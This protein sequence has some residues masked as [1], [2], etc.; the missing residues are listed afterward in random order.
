[1]L[2]LFKMVLITGWNENLPIY[3]FHLL[4]VFFERQ[5]VLHC[6]PVR[7]KIDMV[8]YPSVFGLWAISLVDTVQSRLRDGPYKDVH[9]TFWLHEPT[10]PFRKKSKISR[11]ILGF[12][13]TKSQNM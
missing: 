4:I 11:E 3:L 7:M 13:N 9:A 1:M 12:Q 6:V 10:F 5:I 2:I 8:S